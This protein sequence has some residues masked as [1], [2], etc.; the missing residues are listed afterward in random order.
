MLKKRAS[1]VGPGMVKIATIKFLL[2]SP[3]P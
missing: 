3:I 2:G 1:L